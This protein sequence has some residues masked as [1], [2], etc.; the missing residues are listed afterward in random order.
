MTDSLA[1]DHHWHL[2]NGDRPGGRRVELEIKTSGNPGWPVICCRCGT[3]SHR[4]AGA[5]ACFGRIG[6]GPAIEGVGRAVERAVERGA[7][8][9]LEL[10]ALDALSVVIRAAGEST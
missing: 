7:R 6:V 5:H 9:G 3:T 4:T 2:D 1:C 10:D 8:L